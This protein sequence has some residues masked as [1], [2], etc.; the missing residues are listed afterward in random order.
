MKF[1]HIGIVVTEINSSIAEFTQYIDF[2]Q[3]GITENIKSQKVKVCFLKTGG[4]NLELIEATGKDSPIYE[5]SRQGGG[6]HHICFEVKNIQDKISELTKKGARLIVSP[7]R[8]F[9]NRLIAFLFLNMKSTKY[10]LIE[11]AEE[12]SN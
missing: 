2:E 9:E 1:H 7:V 4:I 6:I 8:G 12:K 3:I 11:L 10:N 5:F